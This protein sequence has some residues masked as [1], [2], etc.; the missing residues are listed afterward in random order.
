MARGP[1]ESVAAKLKAAFEK[2]GTPLKPASEVVFQQLG[3][4]RVACG[5]EL[6]VLASEID[7][8]ARSLDEHGLHVTAIHNHMVAETPHMYWM[9]WYGVADAAT[10]ARGVAAALEHTN[11]ARKFKGDM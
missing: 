1:A 3:N 8:V 9:H 10:L 4:G 7:A 11:G 6:F 5:G 2:S